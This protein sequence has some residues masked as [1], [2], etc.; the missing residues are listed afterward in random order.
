LRIY[1]V[2]LNVGFNPHTQRA[3][4]NIYDIRNEKTTGVGVKLSIKYN[5]HITNRKNNLFKILKNE[6]KYIKLQPF[7]INSKKNGIIEPQ[8]TIDEILIILP[9]AYS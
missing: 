4:E 5:I 9:I 2:F 8:P 3:K 7:N 1:L 6:I